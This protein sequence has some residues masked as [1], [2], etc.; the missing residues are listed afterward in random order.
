[1]F[2]FVDLQKLFERYSTAANGE[3]NTFH[4]AVSAVHKSFNTS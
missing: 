3:Q 4:K 1:M 2:Y